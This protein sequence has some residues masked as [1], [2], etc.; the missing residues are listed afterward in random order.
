MR[1][2]EVKILNMFFSQ[3]FSKHRL[4]VHIRTTSQVCF[5]F[6]CLHVLCLLKTRIERNEI[7]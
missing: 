6:I 5:F 7:S 2:N 4:W 3:I 1:K